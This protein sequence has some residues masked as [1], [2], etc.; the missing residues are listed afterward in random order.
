ML[1]LVIED[2]MKYITSVY[3]NIKPNLCCGL[4]T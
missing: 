3:N 1:Y 4:Y 2:D